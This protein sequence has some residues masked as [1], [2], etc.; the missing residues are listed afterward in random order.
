MILLDFGYASKLCSYAES[1]GFAGPIFPLQTITKKIA[2][3][4]YCG[5]PFFQGLRLDG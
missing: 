1:D 4:T 3:T 2:G 5:P